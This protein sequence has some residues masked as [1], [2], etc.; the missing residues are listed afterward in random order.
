MFLNVWQLD[1][2]YF[3]TSQNYKFDIH[4]FLSMHTFMSR[5]S[6]RKVFFQ[7][8]K[9]TLKFIGYKCCPWKIIDRP[10]SLFNKVFAV[11]GLSGQYDHCRSDTEEY[12]LS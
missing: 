2:T 8:I 1:L 4:V 12:E 10:P 5:S 3:L 6:L 9:R 7:L 11:I